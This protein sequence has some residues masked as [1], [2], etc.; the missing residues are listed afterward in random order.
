MSKI[1]QNKEKKRRAILASAQDVFLSD[2]YVLANMDKIS[3]QAQMTKQTVYRYF[4]SK[5]D[6]FQ[7][8]LRKIGEQFDE[9]Y[10]EHLENPDTR[11]A[12]TGFAKEFIAFHLSEEHIA[13][14]RLL[15]AESTKAPEILDS[16]KSVG[17]NETHEKLSLFFTE[18]LKLKEAETPIRFWIGMLLSLRDEVLMELEKP[19]QTKIDH[20]AEQATAFLL[21][22]I[23]AS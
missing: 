3:A 12:L 8:T 4:P 11:A 17:S 15:I 2:G 10:L 16:F 22:A 6:L 1:E 19:N 13:T 9:S 23:S 14:Y 21:V 5:I 7:A 18:R 20:H